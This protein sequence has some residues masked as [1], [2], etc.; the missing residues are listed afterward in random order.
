MEAKI[1]KCFIA[2][3]SDT[4]EERKICDKVFLEINKGIGNTFGFRIESW[5]WER[6]S[7]PAFGKDGQAVINEQRGN[8]YNIFIGIMWKRF[9]EPTPRA[10]SGTEEE[11]EDAYDR[12]VRKEPVEIMFYFNNAAIGMDEIV[13]EQIGKVQQFQKKISHLGGLYSSFNGVDDFQEKLRTH[14]TNYFL[15]IYKKEVD[16]TPLKGSVLAPEKVSTEISMSHLFYLNDMEATFAHINADK[17]FLEDI[18][19]A[20]DIQKI[21]A[22]KKSQLV[23]TSNLSQITDAIDAEGIKYVFLGNEL[24]GKTACCKYLFHRY[25]SLGLTPVLLNGEDI[26]SNIKLDAVE[27]II[28]HKIS[29]QY[30]RPFTIEE[31]GS[32]KILLIIDDFNKSAK[33]KNKYWHILIKNLETK[34]PNIILTGSPLMAIDDNYTEPFVNFDMYGILEFGPVLRKEIVHKWKTLNL[35][36][37]FIDK[38]ELLR[39]EDEAL[40]HIKTAIGKNYFPVYPFYILSMLQAMEAGSVVNQNYSIHG[41]YYENLINRCFS[42]FIK[43]TKDINLFYNYLTYFCYY[44]FSK[45]VKEISIHE[46]REFHKLYCEKVDIT[47]SVEKIMQTFD[48]AHLLHINQKVTVKEKYVYYFFVA[49]YLSD[50]I[51]N[52]TEAKETISKMSR[53]IF[54][55]DYANIILFVTHLSKDKFIIDELIRNADEIFKNIE[56]ASLE[57]DI[58][59]INQL[60]E[61]IPQQVLE[62]VDVD[63]SRTAELLEEDETE[64]R[65]KEF[66]NDKGSYGNFGLEDDISSID[67]LAWLTMAFKTVDILGQIA[68]KH[69]GEM[70]GE[71][72]IKLVNST[73]NLGLRFLG[74]Y[75]QL[76]QN[77][78]GEIVEHLTKIVSGK[79][80]KD[81]YS[82][83]KSIEEKTKDFIFRLCF[84][85]TFGT[86]KRISNAVSDEKLKI[87]FAKVLDD[88]PYNSYRLIDMGIKLIYSGLPMQEI[89]EMKADVENNNLCLMVLRNLVIDHQHMFEVTHEERSQ[90]NAIFGTTIKDQLTISET[91]KVM[92][93]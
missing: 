28:E 25:F 13:L 67:F 89:K 73:Y 64:K 63:K 7:R 85:A 15:N 82:M 40:N 12:F 37:K 6:D 65:E 77:N 51:N 48:E 22:S 80:F 35:D 60:V 84:M 1:Y 49:K 36:E 58:A 20:P 11:F 30:S 5:K 83:K 57:D 2:S 79:H 31:I 21:D 38:N 4:K 41:F 33:G 50:N 43:N 32:E 17:V 72:K 56:P 18:Y 34:F 59:G 81:Q 52:G 46:F 26:H 76:L 55:D 45:G 8:D 92:K 68:K 75:L 93:D 16:L 71:L 70:D 42:K 69:W 39:K 19:V 23:K 61:S 10:Q 27:K 47:Y 24:A 74:F 54:R 14:L 44:L 62:Q 91:S 66:E 88:N 87:T 9:G 29:L 86:T 90:L 78:S 3:P 53:R